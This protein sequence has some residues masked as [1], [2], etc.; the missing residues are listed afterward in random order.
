MKHLKSNHLLCFLSALLI[1]CLFLAHSALAQEGTSS[2]GASYLTF[3]VGPKSIALG[4]TKA[5]L[6]GD[7]FNW[8][9]NPAT[10]HD[11]EGSGLGISHSQWIVDT[12]YDNLSGHHRINE[13]FI[14]SGG[15]IYT[16]RPDIQGYDDQGQETEDLKNNNYQVLIGLGITPVKQFTAGMNLK[17]FRETLDEWTASGMGVDI[18]ALYTIEKPMT[19]IG[20]SAQ[21]L[22][23][24]IRFDSHGEPLPLTIR[25]GAYHESELIPDDL[26]VALAFDL[27]KP[28]YENIYVS[29]G[30]E[31]EVIK[32]LAVRAGYCGQEYRPG[33]GFTF[34]GGIKVKEALMVDYA[35]TDY[36]D[37]GS[38]HRVSVYFSIL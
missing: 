12:K 38:F 31:V 7:P 23:P 21:N 32:M 17:F 5:A 26:G 20:F 1:P 3:P 2:A 29:A 33:G 34:G 22:G 16:Y 24:D 28:R 8:L 10:L 35:W 19:K 18:G 11:M 37:L 4:E 25:F 13:K 15:I 30:L 14:I 9:S 6:S 27:V 36:G